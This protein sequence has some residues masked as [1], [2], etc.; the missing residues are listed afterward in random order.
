MRRS[1]AVWR[2]ESEST[3][4]ALYSSLAILVITSPNHHNSAQHPS[5][6]QIAQHLAMAAAQ[7]DLRP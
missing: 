7:P 4:Y 6:A 5:L 2:V 3:R 1:E